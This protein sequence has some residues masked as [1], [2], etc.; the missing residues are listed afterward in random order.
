[1]HND[2]NVICLDLIGI[3]LTSNFN[4]PLTKVMPNG[5]N[6]MLFGVGFVELLLENELRGWSRVF[7]VPQSHST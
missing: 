2:T 1:M 6:P 4:L 7:T 5:Q 3:A